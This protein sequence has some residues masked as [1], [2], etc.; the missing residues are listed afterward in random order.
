MFERVEIFNDA[1][2]DDGD[3]AGLIE[4]WV[5]IFIRRNSVRGPARVADAE[6]SGDR[7]GFQQARETVIDFPLFLA[8]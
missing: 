8:K 6:I 1:V 4:M 7:L 3:F 2:V 5:G